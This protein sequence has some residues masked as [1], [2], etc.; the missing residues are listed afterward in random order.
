MFTKKEAA[1]TVI[2]TIIL[3]FLFT[4]PN[5]Q[6]TFLKFLLI[7]F[8]VLGINV[9]AKKVSSYYLDSE[10]DINFWEIKRY[11][12]RPHSHFRRPFPAWVFMPLITAVITFGNF[13][14]MAAMT[15]EVKPKVY[16][17]AKR[18]GLYS[19]SEM[20]EYHIGLIAAF[21]VLA[22]LF[23]AVVGYL[24]GYGDFTRLNIFYAFFNM[25][26]LSDLDGNKIFFGSL[27]LW[28]FVAALVFIGLGYVF[29]GI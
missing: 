19:F 23:F 18:F 22:N 12:F 16:R 28:S 14:W 1:V 7:I 24:M 15:F 21:G 8:L 10:I 6:E 29:L 9:L 13:I 2:V 17:A 4:F 25:I 3:A 5:T 20:T 27:V 11:G 26:P